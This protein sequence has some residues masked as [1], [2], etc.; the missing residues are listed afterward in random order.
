[1]HPGA[2]VTLKSSVWRIVAVSLAQLDW[3]RA[4]AGVPVIGDWTRIWLDGHR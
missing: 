3:P 1:M 4:S 2:L